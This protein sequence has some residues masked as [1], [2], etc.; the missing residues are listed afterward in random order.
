MY[1]LKLA[2]TNAA[3]WRTSLLKSADLPTLGR[4]MIATCTSM[5]LF[6]VMEW[7]KM[8]RLVHVLSQYIYISMVICMIKLPLYLWQQSLIY[9]FLD[10]LLAGGTAAVPYNMYCLSNASPQRLAQRLQL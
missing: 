9:H 3:R 10:T 6:Q 8:L 4:P 5:A 7:T 1:A 2:L